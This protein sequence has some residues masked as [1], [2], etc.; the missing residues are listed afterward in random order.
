MKH[1]VCIKKY[2]YFIPE[3][4]RI[5]VSVLVDYNILH[6]RIG[7]YQTF[8]ISWRLVCA[9]LEKGFETQ[10][11]NKYKIHYTCYIIIEEEREFLSGQFIMYL[12]CIYTMFPETYL[13]PWYA[14][15]T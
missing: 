3:E 2:G 9:N 5:D 7:V 4:E 13:K 14:C 10:Y 11:Q 8:L 12:I 15:I 6:K 1:P